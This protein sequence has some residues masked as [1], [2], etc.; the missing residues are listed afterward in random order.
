MYFLCTICFACSVAQLLPQNLKLSYSL[1]MHTKYYVPRP[2]RCMRY[3]PKIIHKCSAKIF[4]PSDSLFEIAMLICQQFETS[5][6]IYF[7]FFGAK[8]K[9]FEL[10]LSY[11]CPK[12]TTKLMKYVNSSKNWSS[13]QANPKRVGQIKQKQVNIHAATQNHRISSK[14]NTDKSHCYACSSYQ[15]NHQIN[16]SNVNIKR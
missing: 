13:Y 3:Q 11:S 6:F 4:N 15:I 12:N 1:I 16:E 9:T 14:R 7:Y 5:L 10:M 2:T 8:H